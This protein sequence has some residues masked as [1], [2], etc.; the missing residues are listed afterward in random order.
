MIGVQ[1]GAFSNEAGIG[2]EA[3]AHG[4]ARTNQPCPV[5]GWSP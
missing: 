5:K 4:A 2:T 1:R 3:L